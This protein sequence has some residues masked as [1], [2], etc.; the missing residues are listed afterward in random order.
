M[1]R[2]LQ[3]QLYTILT[4]AV[5]TLDLPL[6]TRHVDGLA[7]ELT[8]AIAALLA[9]ADATIAELSPVPYR[10][11]EAAVC[12]PEFEESQFAGCTTRIGL[13]VDYDS[14]AGTVAAKL[15]R[16]PDVTALEISDAHTVA[17]TVDPQSLDAWRWWLHQVQISPGAVAFQGLAA[18]ATGAKDGV[19]VHLHGDGV[20]ELYADRDAA[21]LM[22][23]IAPAKP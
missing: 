3:Q 16:Q 2:E 9:E 10:V 5:A 15:R 7:V 6:D 8:P 12:D 14:P 23:L 11:A 1:S 19:T 20:A 4:T 22:C 21:R 17:V 18:T 13:D